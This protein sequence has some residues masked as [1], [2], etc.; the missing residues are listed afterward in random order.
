[1]SAKSRGRP[2]VRKQ[3]KVS[4]K[5]SRM[6]R[7]KQKATELIQGT[8][9]PVPSLSNL[10]KVLDE[11]Y[12]YS[13]IK[14]TLQVLSE[15]SLPQ[16]K[17]AIADIFTLD[18]LIAEVATFKLLKPRTLGHVTGGDHSTKHPRIHHYRTFVGSDYDQDV[19]QVGWSVSVKLD[20]HSAVK[21]RR[22]T[23]L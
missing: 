3:Q 9:A 4:E 15:R 5:K 19:T 17:K 7:G 1:M 12:S 16:T 8:L 2:K 6:S 14:K 21:N 22:T 11:D 20:S 18:E 13:D 23:V 10:V